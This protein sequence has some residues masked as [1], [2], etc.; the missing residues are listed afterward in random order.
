MHDFSRRRALG[1]LAAGTALAA[2]APR[3]LRAAEAETRVGLQG[4][5]PVAYF[6]D[7][8]PEKGVPQFTAAFDDTTYWFKNAEHRTLFV[9]NPD[10]YA[11]QF[12]GFCAVTVSRGGKYEADPTAWQIADGK[13]YVF[14]AKDAQH[15]FSGHETTVIAKANANWPHLRDQP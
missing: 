7:H 6:T 14:G 3:G 12:E 4:Y 2:L 5:D 1:V 13:L 11:P 10:R 9:A 8:K 15:Y